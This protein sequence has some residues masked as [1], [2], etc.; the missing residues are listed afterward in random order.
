VADD[1]GKQ[2]SALALDDL[3][4]D[5]TLAF[6]TYLE[7]ARGNSVSTRNQRLVALR[8]FVEHLLR[9]DPTRAAQYRRILDIPS[10]KAGYRTAS[11]LEPE[12]VA[13]LFRQPDRRTVAGRRHHVLL[14]FLYNTGTRVSE[15]LAVCVADIEFSGAAQ[16]RV[17]GKGNRDRICPLWRETVDAIEEVLPGDRTACR[18]FSLPPA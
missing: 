8:C 16:V 4:A 5:R 18:D 3:V 6:L 11:Y 7:D 12:E 14:L 1:A 2:V 15:A 9:H 17:H 10:K 13:V